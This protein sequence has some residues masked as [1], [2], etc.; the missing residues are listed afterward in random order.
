[1]K[2]YILSLFFFFTLVTRVE[3]LD[4]DRPV[5]HKVGIKLKVISEEETEALGYYNLELEEEDYKLKFSTT[6]KLK[7]DYEELTI[8]LEYE[9]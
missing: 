9:W 7:K 2:V 8:D 5:K 3:A 1:M 6:I 4:N